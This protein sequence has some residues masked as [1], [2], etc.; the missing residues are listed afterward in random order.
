MD[1]EI[2]SQEVNSTAASKPEKKRSA[3]Y[4]AITLQEAY[5]FTAKINEKFSLAEVTRSEI[6]F[7]LG[8]SAGGVIIR[9]ISVAGQFGFLTKN[10]AEGKYKV[11]QLFMDIFMPDNDRDRRLKRIDAFS[12]PAIYQELII[13]FDNS[14]VPEELVNTLIKYHDITPAAAPLAASVF[15]ESA[16]QVEVLTDNRV[17]RVALNRSTLSKRQYAEIE[18]IQPEAI[19]EKTAEDPV[20]EKV[21]TNGHAIALSAPSD[22]EQDS[23]NDLLKI[24]IYLTKQKMAVFGYPGEITANDLR[25]VKQQLEVILLRI[26]LEQEEMQKGTEVPS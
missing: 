22:K 6:A 26:Q 11:S 14:V 3:A 20:E 5:D 17:L 1:T 2:S 15:I 25:I 18:T 10:T 16:K 9:D 23:W 7:A 19:K 4:P 13:K 21:S 24:P 12:S 8:V